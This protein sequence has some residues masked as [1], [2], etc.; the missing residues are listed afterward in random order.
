MAGHHFDVRW[1]LLLPAAALY[2]AL[3]WVPAW[4]Y[5]RGD[6]AWDATGYLMKL[7]VGAPVGMMLGVVAANVILAKRRVRRGP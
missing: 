1:R 6:A 3:M 5:H 7:A 2:V 4:L